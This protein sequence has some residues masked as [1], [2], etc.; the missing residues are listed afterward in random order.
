M[1]LPCI[2]VHLFHHG[3]SAFGGKRSCIFII[4]SLELSPLPQT[5]KLKHNRKKQPTFLPVTVK[6]GRTK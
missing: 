4:I 1:T 6:D 3:F 2:F 5:G